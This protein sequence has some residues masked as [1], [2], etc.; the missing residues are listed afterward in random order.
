MYDF[1][2]IDGCHFSEQVYRDAI[3]SF[4]FLNTNGIIIFDDF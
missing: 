4:R 2:C 1:I 3:N